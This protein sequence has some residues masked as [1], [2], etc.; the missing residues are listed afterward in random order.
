MTR[1]NGRRQALALPSFAT[2]LLAATVLL[3]SLQVARAQSTAGNPPA[4]VR[5]APSAPASS[6]DEATELAKK[7]QNPVGDLYS[8][9]FQGNTNFNTGTKGGK[10]PVNF[11]L[12]AFYNAIRPSYTGAWTLRTQATLIF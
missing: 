12:G 6:D 10:L 4:T 9:P 7:L 1:L 5:L 8:F 3:A 2:A 11:Q